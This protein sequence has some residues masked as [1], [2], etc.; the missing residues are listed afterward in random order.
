MDGVVGS[1]LHGL[2]TLV[3]ATIE[4][5]NKWGPERILMLQSREKSLAP[6]GNQKTIVRSSNL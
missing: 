3:P 2:A 6:A 5:K 4:H 1:Q